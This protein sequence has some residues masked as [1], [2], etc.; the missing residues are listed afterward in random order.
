VNL[1]TVVFQIRLDL[2]ENLGI[3]WVEKKDSPI[4]SQEFFCEN[5]NE[6]YLIFPSLALEGDLRGGRED[7]RNMIVPR[8]VNKNKVH[9]VLKIDLHTNGKM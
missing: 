1:K 4:R 9:L 6:Y 2:L 7:Q 5:K 8:D 3:I